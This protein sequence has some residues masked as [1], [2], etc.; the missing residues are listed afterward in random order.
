[1]F[2]QKK[3]IFTY[4]SGLPSF[5]QKKILQS[6]IPRRRRHFPFRRSTLHAKHMN[7]QEV[8]LSVYK[9]S[10]RIFCGIERVDTGIR[11]LGLQSHN[12]AR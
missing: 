7:I 4:L 1:M 12:L 11:T 6:R 10:R 9:K 2:P 5:F 8:P 3:T